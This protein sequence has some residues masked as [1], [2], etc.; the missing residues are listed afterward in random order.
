MKRPGFSLPAVAMLAMAASA[1]AAP[2]ALTA[3]GTT[4]HVHQI[5]VMADGKLCIV[6]K[7]MGTQPGEGSRGTLLVF[8]VAAN[9][10][11]WE[12]RIEA[13]PGYR[14]LDFAACQGDG[15][16]V[17]VGA[18][19]T[20][21]GK[22]STKHVVAWAYRFDADGKLAASRELD[23]GVPYAFVYAVDADAGGMTVAGSATDVKDRV[24]SN[25]IFFAH[26]DPA[27]RDASIAKLANG[28]FGRGSAARLSGNTLYIAGN[29]EPASDAAMREA[30]D[31]AVSKIVGGK[32]R[33][34]VR[35]MPIRSDRIARTVSAANELV[36]MGDQEG[37]TRLVVIG[38]DGKPRENLQV[39]GPFCRTRTIA[40]S[41]DTVYAIRTECKANGTP[42]VLTAID[43]KTGAELVVSGITGEPGY[44]FALPS[45]VVV[46]SWK[47]DRTLLLQTVPK[48]GDPDA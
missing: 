30:D 27:L 26:L 9:R 25:G 13:P 1:G 21:A 3:P 43:R 23:T 12:R 15:H 39:K 5:A 47:S 4:T 32:Y 14:D 44:L 7:T 16:A 40:A 41:A 46:I 18:E 22:G 29:F 42:A 35:P 6:G 17:H 36:S 8:D 2:V 33:F 48:G 20:P 38:A 19:A 28:A 34:S 45:A 10:V 24:A 11:A 31:Y 37:S